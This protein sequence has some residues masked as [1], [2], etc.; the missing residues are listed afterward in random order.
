M[1]GIWERA[2]PYVTNP[3]V[4][5]LYG[6][7]FDPIHIGHMRLAIE[8]QAQ[9]HAFEFRFIPAW[10]SPLKDEPGASSSHRLAMLELAVAELKRLTGSN[11]FTIDTT[12]LARRGASYTMDTLAALKDEY[13]DDL[14][15]LLMGMDSWQNLNQWHR[16][17]EL[18]EH[19]NLLVV[20]RPDVESKTNLEVVAFAKPR[21]CESMQ[22]TSQ[23][24]G[25]VG[26]IETTP[27][28]VSSTAIRALVQQGQTPAFL[29]C[30]PV[31]QYIQQ[32]KLYNS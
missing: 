16:W 13:R 20:N 30:E 11:S 10:R 9:F 12:E 15:I 31:R 2:Y 19:A 21:T 18:F 4:R 23:T 3:T 14:F 7:S 5:I 32:H 22:L 25:A 28:A 17:Q 6:G 8:C 24:A 26:F 1:G 29:V 27:L